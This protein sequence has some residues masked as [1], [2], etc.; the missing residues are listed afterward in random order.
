MSKFTL[1]AAAFVA[2]SATPALAHVTLET[3]TAPIGSTYKAVARVPHGCKGAATIKVRVRIPE[4]VI[5][6]KPMPKA[7]WSLETVK[8]KYEKAYDYYGTP[9]SEGVREVVWSGG[10]LLDE[11]YDEFVFRAYLTT[12]LQPDTMLYVPIVQECEGGA[13]ERWIEIPAA[14]K[15]PDDYKF[16]A[17]GLKLTPKK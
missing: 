2:L 12:D 15:V 8:G 3:Q 6:V 5:A 11:H 7:G 17:P 13:V 4:G 14:G 10:K 16:P 1:V 9:T